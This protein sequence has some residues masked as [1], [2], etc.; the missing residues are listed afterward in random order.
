MALKSQL[1]S[2][3]LIISIIFFLLFGAVAVFAV[4]TP[5]PSAPMLCTP[6]VAH[7]KVSCRVGGDG[8]RDPSFSWRDGINIDPV[9]QYWSGDNP[10]M[11]IVG[12]DIPNKCKIDLRIEGILCNRLDPFPSFEVHKEGTVSGNACFMDMV[13]LPFGVG[14]IW[15]GCTDVNAPPFVNGGVTYYYEEPAPVCNDECSTGQYSC[16][17]S[18]RIECGNFDGDSCLEWGNKID[19][20]YGCALGVCEEPEPLLYNISEKLYFQAEP[21]LE[22]TY[23]N[24]EDEW[25]KISLSQYQKVTAT[26][27][28]FFFMQVDE[29]T[30]TFAYDYPSASLGVSDSWAERKAKIYVEHPKGYSMSGASVYTSIPVSDTI[31]ICVG[32]AVNDKINNLPIEVFETLGKKAIEEAAKEGVIWAS[33]VGILLESKK[34]MDVAKFVACTQ[35]DENNYVYIGTTNEDGYAEVWL[36]EGQDTEMMARWYDLN[37][38]YGGVSVVNQYGFQGSKNVKIEEWMG[39]VP[40]FTISTK[41]KARVITIRDETQKDI[42]EELEQISSFFEN[43]YGIEVNHWTADDWAYAPKPPVGGDGTDLKIYLARLDS[44]PGGSPNNIGVN[45]QN[46][47]PTLVYEGVAW[48]VFD[49]TNWYEG[50]VFGLVAAESS[51]KKFLIAGLGKNGFETAV[52]AFTSKEMNKVV[53]WTDPVQ[54]ETLK[55][56]VYQIKGAS[57]VDIWEAKVCI[58]GPKDDCKNTNSNGIA[59]FGKVPTGT[60]TI[61][62][63]K[64]GYS[65]DSTTP[66]PRQVDLNSPGSTQWVNFGM[67]ANEWNY[68][69]PEEVRVSERFYV[70]TNFTN[71]GDELVEFSYSTE[72]RGAKFTR[73]MLQGTTVFLAPGNSERARW[74]FSAD[75]EGEG[76]LWIIKG[77]Q[78][79][80]TG[81]K[82]KVGPLPDLVAY[83]QK[84]DVWDYGGRVGTDFQVSVEVRNRE[85]YS[86]NITVE[87]VNK[88]NNA[89]LEKHS[90]IQVP[91][92]WSI[93]GFQV[94]REANPVDYVFNVRYDG[95]VI[96]SKDFTAQA[97][98]QVNV[99]PAPTSI[100]GG[101]PSVRSPAPANLP[102]DA[103][104]AGD[105]SSGSQNA[106]PSMPRNIQQDT[107][108]T[109]AQNGPTGMISA[110][111]SFPAHIVNVLN[112]A[113]SFIIGLFSW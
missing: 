53:K 83:I 28:S 90:L 58:S 80:N 88:S 68:E 17:G 106:L 94:W 84:I 77:N 51:L 74:E 46:Y 98:T 6:D 29:N 64:K 60:Y 3:F 72:L 40:E 16:N 1:K 27:P 113:W 35:E 85:N 86:V 55:S 96:D 26:E 103:P 82:I 10:G 25:Q 81:K 47:N 91:Y 48:Q 4:Y 79:I 52:D 37:T 69:M 75:Q 112:N 31:S 30:R 105:S 19:C 44:L 36:R 24:M 99:P 110:I 2:R 61:S 87:M 62:V 108:S 63:E 93:Y 100:G 9:S 56:H 89:V 23:V 20:E 42:D 14:G 78:E 13:D 5:T 102:A 50:D 8:N 33:G 57:T 73:L 95:A 97:G 107:F 41:G 54:Y 49:G 45:F 39:G 11:R 104:I 66:S 101:S 59:D 12:L 34:A 43:E 67:T 22:N 7:D 109:P 71:V 15:N 32:N 70:Y 18:A 92:G 65:V 76:T 38:L 21:Y 111:S